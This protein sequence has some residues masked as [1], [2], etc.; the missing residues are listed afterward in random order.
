VI[1]VFALLKEIFGE[2]QERA[3]ADQLGAAL[4]LAY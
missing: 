3:L 2:D 4:M 1:Y